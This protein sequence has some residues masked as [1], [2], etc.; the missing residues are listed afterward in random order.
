MPIQLCVLG[1]GKIGTSIGLAL[2]NHSKEITRIGF[3]RDQNVSK[4]ALELQA[5][6]QIKSE[7]DQTVLH[8]DI[9][10]L[11]LPIDE[12]KITIDTIIPFIKPDSILIDTSP[13]K[14][15]ISEYLDQKL[16][17]D[18]YFVSLYPTINP[19][20]LGELGNS[21]ENAHQDLFKDSLI[22]IT[23]SNHTN[24]DSLRLA[25]DLSS[26]LGAKALFADPYEVD[27]LLAAT[28][29]L[30]HLISAA[31]IQSVMNQPGWREARK[32]TNSPYHALAQIISTINEREQFGESF[33][34]NKENLSRTIKNM[35]ESLRL[36]DNLIEEENSPKIHN[37]VLDSINKQNQWHEER[38][39]SEWTNG[40]SNV[41]I[42]TSKDFIK[43][44]FT[45]GNKNRGKK[46]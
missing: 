21:I 14:L 17:E 4:K 6:D 45:F 10:I 38:I 24:N 12:I 46:N 16:P 5:F 25:A 31:Y 2:K 42:P 35:I 26:Y 40:E 7:I 27:G 36:I 34:L 3:D 22:V 11:A 43:N 18:R 39:L 23:T 19:D 20:Y 29:L 33:I 13:I 9:I 41:N 37:W 44:I 15:K 30:P 28:E 32:L 1:L 8:A